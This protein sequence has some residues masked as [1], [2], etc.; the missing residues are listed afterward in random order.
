MKQLFV[1][2][3]IINF[4][5]TLSACSSKQIKS[6]L[7]D[8]SRDTYEKN[9]RKKRNESIWERNYGEEPLSY[10]QYQQERKTISSKP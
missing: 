1:C 5:F 2:C 8:I 9:V 10:D 6:V 7:D 3:I 4:I